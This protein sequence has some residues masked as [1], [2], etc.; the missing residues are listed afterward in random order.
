MNGRL[1][2][3]DAPTYASATF[4]PPR[5]FQYAAHEALRAG[6]RAGHKNQL[7][8]SP[9]GSGKTYLGLRIAHEALLKGRRALFLCDRV[10]LINQTSDTAD[11]YGLS[12][13]GVIQADHWRFNPDLPFQIA[14][15]QT[16]A[17]RQWPAAD[18]VIIDE[19]HT[20]LTV[21][22]EYIRTCPASVIGLSATPFSPG[23]GRLFSNLVN[24]ATMHDLTESGVLVPMRVFSCVKTNM[25]GAATAGGEWT[26]AAA[27]ERGMEIV[28][29][30]VSEWFKF[31]EGRKTIVFASTIRHCEEL[32][33]QF[34]EA[35]VMAAT[36]TSL[37]MPDERRMLLNEYRKHD[38]SLRVLISVEALAKGFDAADVGCVVD[39]RPLRKSLS[40]AIQMW[41]RGLRSSPETGKLDCRLLDHSGNITRFLADYEHI[42][43]NGLD[44]LDA[45]EKLDKVIRKDDKEKKAIAC[46]SCG[47]M[48]FGLRCMACGFAAQSAALVESLPGK[49]QEVVIGGKKLADDKRH[50]YAQL[51]T[52]ARLYSAP[53][54]QR[55][56]AA[57]LFRKI[58]LDWPPHDYVFEK[59]ENV[60]IERNTLNRIKATNIA[61]AKG[62][63]NA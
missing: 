19:C 43:Y 4:P 6:R 41:G 63:A 23:L 42:F 56:R 50:L 12:A 29:D 31:G 26:N 45:G 11:R 46:P 9:T 14:S 2:V 35:G 48:P 58:T 3:D 22:V 8:M 13:H 57:H 55:G 53:D 20:Q 1:F 7:L 10:T 21:W 44:A 47:Y 39:C 18:V 33:R 30:V 32:C 28:G 54:K 59:T 61:A 60:P 34:V 36:F 5:S 62:R 51:C 27:E 49:M 25:D 52:Y 38:S 24:A 17:R 40:T 37:T 16:L 15:A